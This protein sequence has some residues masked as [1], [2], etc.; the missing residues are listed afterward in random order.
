MKKFENM[1]FCTDLDGTILNSRLEISKEN[2]DAIEYFKSEGG[3]FT[4][5]TG[6][7]PET[8][9]DI[10]E[11]IKPNAPVGCLNGG[12]IYDVKEGKFLWKKPLTYDCLDLVKHALDEIPDMSAQFNTEN[13]IFFCRDNSAMVRFRQLTG[14]EYVP[15]GCEKLESELLKIV[16]GHTD[17]DKIDKL[18][19]LL[20]SHPNAYKYD[21]IR[22]ELTLYEI[23][24]KGVSK[25]NVITKMAEILGLDP[26][27]TIAVGDYNNDVS[28]IKAA[29]LGFA[30]ENAVL[31]AKAAADYIT[32]CN[33]SH[34]I[35]AI[36]DG[37]DKG[38]YKFKGEV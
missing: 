23:L 14:V 32:V 2:L 30:V 34:A 21:F 1:L 12:G 8:F 6:R 28:M 25:G 33:D 38:I 4:F 27:K 11:T 9:T 16:F 7:V 15:C 10:Y 29:G 36:V 17:V 35:K 31:E 26:K 37:L 24:P 5:I 19:R 13:G 20:N 3:L 18:A 22:S